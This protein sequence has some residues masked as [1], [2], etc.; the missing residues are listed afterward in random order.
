MKVTVLAENTA[1]REGLEAEHGLSLYLETAGRKILVDM[2]QTDVFA[3]NAEILGID[4]RQVDIAV[5]SHGHYDHGGGLKTFLQSNTKAPVYI[6]ADAFGQHY[7]GTQKY[8]GLDPALAH[9]PRLIPVKGSMQLAQDLWLHDCNGL[10]WQIHSWGLNQKNADGFSPDSFS[11]ELYIQIT[12]GEKRV[13]I[14]GCSHKGIENIAGHFRPDVLIGG[15]HLNKQE[16]PYALQSIAQKLLESCGVCY[17]GHCTGQKQY[18]YMKAV[19]Q[20]RLQPL[21]T[22][23]MIEL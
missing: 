19:M 12:E 16:D 8:I 14:S 3:H 20:Q 17:T 4:L 18:A 11:H 23:M 9:H 10:G 5:L 2:G 1:C 21:S 15:F 13:L 22:G 6:H 7:N